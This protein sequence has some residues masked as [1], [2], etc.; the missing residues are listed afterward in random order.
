MLSQ[1]STL[2]L[3]SSAGGAVLALLAERFAWCLRSSGRRRASIA[4]AQQLR[5]QLAEDA[6][7]GGLSRRAVDDRLAWRPPRAVAIADVDGF[8]FVNDE[9]GHGVGDEVLRA[10]VAE[11]R[12]ACPT[13]EVGRLG[14]DELVVLAEDPGEV[15]ALGDSRSIVAGPITATISIG[16]CTCPV[17]AGH[18][19]LACA[20]LRMYVAKR[21]RHRD[22]DPAATPAGEDH[23]LELYERDSE[24]CKRLDAYVRDGLARDEGVVLVVTA[25]H[26]RQ[27]AGVLPRDP[28]IRILDAR[29]TLMS[30]LDDDGQPDE[31][32]FE[33]VVVPVLDRAATGRSGVRAFGEMVDLLWSAGHVEEAIRLEGLWNR[34]A[35]RRVFRLLCAY[36]VSTLAD[37]RNTEALARMCHQHSR[38][39][40]IA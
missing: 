30:L 10:A 4:Q 15:L 3:A 5:A 14:G 1:M 20:D 8:K 12:A 23:L 39:G 11:L 6:L 25:E 17:S 16:A 36:R 40:A 19:P 38:V 26:T 37:G 27:L 18:D 13:A 33:Q 9:H 22:D 2:V 29:E 28:R 34:A 35:E 32:L 21:A 7:T 24:L 31:A